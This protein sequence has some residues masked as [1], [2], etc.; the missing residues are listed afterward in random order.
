MKAGFSDIPQHFLK[1]KVFA[2]TSSTDCAGRI[3]D[4]LSVYVVIPPKMLCLD[5]K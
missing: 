1:R 5:N 2:N 3:L 4:Y